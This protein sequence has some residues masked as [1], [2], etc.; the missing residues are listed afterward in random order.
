MSAAQP[1]AVSRYFMMAFTWGL[2]ERE[3]VGSFVGVPVRQEVGAFLGER[4]KLVLVAVEPLHADLPGAFGRGRPAEED[5]AAV[6]RIAGVV[7]HV[8]AEGE[9]LPAAAVDADLVDVALD[10][11]AQDA[12]AVPG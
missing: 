7:L 10:R 5:H 3:R 4:H 12:L 11:L 1:N 8:G 2:E 9:L 6:G